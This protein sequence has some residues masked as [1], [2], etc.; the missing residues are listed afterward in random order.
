M[1]I[2]FDKPTF[3]APALIRSNFVM[4]S[5]EQKARQ[6]VMDA[7]NLSLSRYGGQHAKWRELSRYY[8]SLSP[9]LRSR[10]NDQPLNTKISRDPDLFVPR[11]FTAVE[12]ATPAWIFAVLGQTPKVYARKPKYKDSAGAVEAMLKYDWERS[13]VVMRS[14]NVAKQ[15][16][17]YGTGI[18]K[19]GY[20]YEEYEIN[21]SYERTIPTGFTGKGEIRTRTD[22]F[23][24]K[25][26]VVR[27]DGPWLEPWNV[28]NV[29]P[30]PFYPR[31]PEMR[32]VNAKRW[33]D[34][35]TLRHESD[36]HELH[37]GKP[38][39]KHLDRIPR[40]KKGYAEEIWQADY[41]DDIAEAMGW[42][43][44]YGVAQNRYT[45]MSGDHEDQDLVEIIEHWSRDDRVIYLANGETPILDGPNPFDDKEIPFVA[46]RATVLDNQFWGY[47]ILH[48]IQRSQEE[49]NSHENLMLRQTQLNVMNI[50][51]SSEDL[52]LPEDLSSLEPGDVYQT[53]FFQ[54]K[55]LLVPLF[56]G[57][58]LPPEAYR[59]RE[60]IDNT[61]QT[62]IGQ[63]G[64]RQNISSGTATEAQL[65]SAMVES[66][67]R[68]QALGGELT[69]ANEIAR[70]F[71]SRR[72]QFLKDEGEEFR[73]LGPKGA[74]YPRVTPEDIAGEY[75][76]LTAG[77]HMH[78]SR[79]VLRQQILQAIALI[80]GNPA[81]LSI[82]DLPEIWQEFWKMCDL[83]YPER[84]YSPPP[85]RT[86]NPKKENLILTQGEWI[87]VEP[88][89]DHEEHLQSHTQAMGDAV[90]NGPE[91]IEVLQ[92]H[93]Q[94]HQDFVKQMQA[95][96]P[97]QEQPGIKGYSGNTPNLENAT[98]T[99][100][101]LQSRVGG[102]GAQK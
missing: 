6:K 30:D 20:R 52:G 100:A 43:Q 36:Q 28:F 84:F 22:S 97:Q 18:A 62:T 34:R 68:L 72:Q 49:L 27:F 47:G 46:T 88:N 10:E 31:I 91:A 14:Q 74:D 4:G 51:A 89:D 58:P 40:Q 60:Q 11:C 12:A 56:Q 57:R 93:I 78:A 32:Y 44:A 7:Q 41:G 95:Q 92:R 83:P 75:D 9:T 65:E 101:G 42:T 96:T 87:E 54:D 77:Q 82:S 48:P 80:G 23:K 66:R 64:Y 24:K 94:E 99:E 1:A 67:N 71:H 17:K 73:I 81:I 70:L 25:E 33:T 98:E 26:S 5:M 13:E 45:S 2:A 53:P 79:D 69:Y 3:P 35:K 90:G 16:F 61:I 8:L 85:Q 76:F 59:I 29:H 50:W 39:Y 86:M 21:R 37:T 102:A 63:P 55:P 15:M 19:V 38:L